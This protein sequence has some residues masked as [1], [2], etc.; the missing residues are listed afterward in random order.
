MTTRKRPGPPPGTA[1]GELTAREAY[2]REQA[3]KLRM[4]NAA[5]R[6]ELLERADVA[7]SLGADRD[8]RPR[9]LSLAGGLRGPNGLGHA[10]A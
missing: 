8:H 2:Y 7:A 10:G 5:R 6:G 1:R 4:A 9:S 3:E